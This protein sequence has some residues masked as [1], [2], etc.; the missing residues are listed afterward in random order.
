MKSVKKV[1]MIKACERNFKC[2]ERGKH[3][4]RHLCNQSSFAGHLG[5]FQFSAT[6]SIRMNITLVFIGYMPRS[7]LP[8]IKN[9]YF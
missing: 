6:N 4:L 8:G 2:K 1:T 9:A 7:G 3:G 5:S